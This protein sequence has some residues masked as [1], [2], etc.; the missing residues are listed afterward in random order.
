MHTKPILDP[1]NLIRPTA[2]ETRAAAQRMEQERLDA[3]RLALD[4]QVSIHNGA[5]ERIAI[6]ERLHALRLPAQPT[7]PLLR[8]IAMQTQLSLRDVLDEQQR[9]RAQSAGERATPPAT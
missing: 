4:E 3:R 8:V 1:T 6:W 7:H 9:R 2:A 5:K